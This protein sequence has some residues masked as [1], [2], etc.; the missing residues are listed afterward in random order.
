M[1]EILEI[2]LEP[3]AQIAVIQ[4]YTAKT[5]IMRMAAVVLH[6]KINNY[7]ISTVCFIIFNLTTFHLFYFFRRHYLSNLLTVKI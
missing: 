2:R 3:V 6:V 1:L 4:Y 7:L 5:A